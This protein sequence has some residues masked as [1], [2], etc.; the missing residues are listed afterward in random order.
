M[1]E[2]NMSISKACRTSVNLDALMK[3]VERIVD[4]QIDEIINRRSKGTVNRLMKEDFAQGNPYSSHNGRINA[5]IKKVQDFQRHL[6]Q[7]NQFSTV[8]SKLRD[9]EDEIAVARLSGRLK[10]SIGRAIDEFSEGLCRQLRIAA[11]CIEEGINPILPDGGQSAELSTSIDQQNGSGECLVSEDQALQGDGDIVMA[12][13]EVLQ[14]KHEKKAAPS[15]N[16]FMGNISQN[17]DETKTFSYASFESGAPREDTIPFQSEEKGA[18]SSVVPVKEQ[19]VL[20]LQ[21]KEKV[22][23]FSPTPAEES[24]PPQEMLPQHNE[25]TQVAFSQSPFGKIDSQSENPFEAIANWRQKEL[26][27]TKAPNGSAEE[28]SI[29]SG[30]MMDPPAEKTLSETSK[31]IKQ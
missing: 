2:R 9:T 12:P 3:R 23:N 8:F 19:N 18:F 26:S 28:D 1:K 31:E 4:E 16:T 22:E 30:P 10:E 15:M 13:A 24:T 29:S 20:S 17:A 6:P 5:K 25:L 27:S 21:D 7:N 11:D 14:Q